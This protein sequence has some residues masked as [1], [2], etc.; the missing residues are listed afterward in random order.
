MPPR[1]VWTPERSKSPHWIEDEMI[2]EMINGGF[3]LE[4]IPEEEGDETIPAIA[5]EEEHRVEIYVYQNFLDLQRN[6]RPDVAPPRRD[7]SPVRRN[8]RNAINADTLERRRRA[9]QAEFAWQNQLRQGQPWFE[10]LDAEVQ[11]MNLNRFP[12]PQVERFHPAVYQAQPDAFQ[13]QL[14]N[15]IDIFQAEMRQQN[16]WNHQE[17]VNRPWNQY[18]Q[19]P[20]WTEIWRSIFRGTALEPSDDTIQ[21][22][23]S[24]RNA[25]KLNPRNAEIWF[26]ES[27]CQLSRARVFFILHLAKFEVVFL[28]LSLN[29]IPCRFANNVAVSNKYRNSVH[30]LQTHRREDSALLILRYR[31]MIFNRPPPSQRNFGPINPQG[32][33]QHQAN[34]RMWRQ[35]PVRFH[36]EG[37]YRPQHQLHDGRNQFGFQHEMLREN[38]N[39]PVPQQRATE[40]WH[41]ECLR[42]IVARLFNSQYTH[43]NNIFGQ[44][45]FQ[46]PFAVP[47]AELYQQNPQFATPPPPRN[48]FVGAAP[49]YQPQQRFEQGPVPQRFVG[50][51]LGMWQQNAN[52]AL[53]D[54][55]GFR[56]IF[57][58]HQHNFG[59]PQ[60]DARRQRGQQAQRREGNRR[61]D[62]GRN[63]RRRG[64]F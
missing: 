18:E 56:Q 30:I 11:R 9:L 35:Q 33:A 37:P 28:N 12:P 10:I 55:R 17:P 52:L 47:Q 44:Q 14:R 7:P 3:L 42:I 40:P 25:T 61:N 19:Q 8:E 39:R 23:E 13:E 51:H 43:H 21:L 41:Q 36:Q 4:E 38:W 34:D 54:Q 24:R 53:P 2:N 1:E 59:A 45:R 16:P 20:F 22:L 32:V 26:M 49:L 29:L 5:E 57:R 62:A 31:K 27:R 60:P 50:P 15:W 6:P 64:R 58:P 46:P 48:R 63:E